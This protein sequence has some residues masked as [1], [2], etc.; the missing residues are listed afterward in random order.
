MKELA[1]VDKPHTG[2]LISISEVVERKQRYG[3]AWQSP[4]FFPPVGIRQLSAVTEN[5][6]RPFFRVIPIKGEKQERL[7]GGEGIAHELAKIV[8][9]ETKSLTLQLPEGKRDLR[10]RDIRAEVPVSSDGT[11]YYLDLVGDF[12][13]PLDL[14]HPWSNR[15]VIE[16]CDQ[17]PTR[18]KK[19]VDLR[20]NINWAAIEIKLP[21]KL[22]LRSGLALDAAGLDHHKQKLKDFLSRRLLY[23][24]KYD[25]IFIHT[26][27]HQARVA[28]A[29]AK[30]VNT[31]LG[32][33]T[34]TTGSKEVL[35]VPSVF[36]KKDVPPPVQKVVMTPPVSALQVETINQPLLQTM[37]NTQT[38]VSG[39]EMVTSIKPKNGFWCRLFK[40]LFK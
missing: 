10:F 33:I 18:G 7:A 24:D 6:P 25:F 20:R 30:R 9:A 2:R 15:L 23:G 11:R 27:D 19:V 8:L 32:S 29:R 35:L 21:D 26:P 28:R 4:V 16:I 5:V 12:D 36:L 22:H 38:L 39:G 17:H 3:N 40:K 13:T 14:A 31:S 34:P 1:R 37:T